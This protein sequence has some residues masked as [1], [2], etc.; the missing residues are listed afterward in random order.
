MEQAENGAELLGLENGGGNVGAI[1]GVEG[2]FAVSRDEYRVVAFGDERLEVGTVRVHNTLNAKGVES[3]LNGGKDG[4]QGFAEGD[5]V[6]GAQTQ[7]DFARGDGAN[8]GA[9]GAFGVG[10]HRLFEGG[11]EP[12]SQQALLCF[13]SEKTATNVTDESREEGFHCVV[14]EDEE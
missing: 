7:K 1:V 13:S 10:G 8:V 6:R 11:N 9:R 14:K 12:T 4:V 5:D 2:I 3:L